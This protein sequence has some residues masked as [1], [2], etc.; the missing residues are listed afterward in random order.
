MYFMSMPQIIRTGLPGHH[1]GAIFKKYE[2]KKGS[3]ICSKDDPFNTTRHSRT[4][5]RPQ[6][7]TSNQQHLNDKEVF[8]SSFAVSKRLYSTH[9]TLQL[10]AKTTTAIMDDY[11][12]GLLDDDTFKVSVLRQKLLG[13]APVFMYRIPKEKSNG[14][15]YLYV[16]YT[17]LYYAMWQNVAP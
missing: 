16:Q 12:M 5:L 13:I 2:P 15:E 1:G 10:T 7:N 6:H 8:I 17:V 14:N 9:S 4:F 3:F 11:D